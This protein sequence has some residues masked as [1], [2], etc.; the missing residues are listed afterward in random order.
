MYKYLILVF[1]AS[2]GH[3]S[4][5]ESETTL[6]ISAQIFSGYSPLSGFMGSGRLNLDFKLSNRLTIGPSLDLA[7]SIDIEYAKTSLGLTTTFEVAKF[8]SGSLAIRQS[9]YSSYVN[10][11]FGRSQNYS[12]LSGSTG[13]SALMFETKGIK[14]GPTIDYFYSIDGKYN[15]NNGLFL[16]LTFSF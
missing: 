7:Q 12:F 10:E 15:A 9:L 1:I 5:A 13:L 11:S 6:P 14:W 16:G 4:F 2:F 8:K 3:L